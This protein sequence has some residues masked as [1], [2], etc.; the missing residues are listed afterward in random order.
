[1]RFEDIDVKSQCG[2]ERPAQSS[3]FIRNDEILE[4]GGVQGAENRKQQQ[5]QRRNSGKA[6]MSPNFE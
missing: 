1:M 4:A 3:G 2:G 6:P 5:Q